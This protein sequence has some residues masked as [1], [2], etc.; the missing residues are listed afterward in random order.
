M[1]E[2][3]AVASRTEEHAKSAAQEFGAKRYY[4]SIDKALDDPEVQAVDICLPHDMHHSVS[5]QSARKGKH[6][7]VEKPMANTLAEA[8]EMIASAKKNGVILMVGQ[9]RRFFEAVLESKRLIAEGKIGRLLHSNIFMLGYMDKPLTPWWSSAEKAG[10]L[11][12]PLWGSHILDYILWISPA[13]PVRVY[14]E[15]Y[16][17]NPNWEGEDEMA[18]VLGFA[19]GTMASVQMSWNARMTPSKG[20]PKPEGGIWSTKD[21]AYERYIIGSEGTI[22]MIDET[23]LILNGEVL[24][25]GPQKPSNF[26]LEIKEFA[27]AIG[28]ERV[29]IASG[30]EVREVMRVTD[31]CKEAIKEGKVIHLDS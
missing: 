24:K 21:N 31:A 28:E 17:D 2:L 30:Q 16:S 14:A 19:D 22:H 3:V 4:T 15:A 7:L 6:I 1:I 26:F 5:V 29:P 8:D 9:S 11:L 27:S 13:E 18:I 20:A 23:E 25:S 12:L 10:G